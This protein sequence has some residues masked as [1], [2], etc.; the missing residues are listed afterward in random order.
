MKPCGAV[1]LWHLERREEA[2]AAVSR[3]RDLAPNFK[4]RH[5]RLNLLAPDEET[6]API[7]EALRAAGLPD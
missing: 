4:V 3:V 5:L 7:V 2:R 1:V 6:I